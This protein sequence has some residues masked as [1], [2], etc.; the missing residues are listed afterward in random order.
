[1]LAN[2]ADLGGD[3]G[4]KFKPLALQLDPSQQRRNAL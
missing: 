4:A 1:M 3:F 2:S